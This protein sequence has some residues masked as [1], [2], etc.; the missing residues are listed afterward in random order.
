[1]K[2]FSKIIFIVF[3][4][5][6]SLCL[7]V[8]VA[9]FFVLKNFDLNKFKPQIV[10]QVQQVLGRQ[11]QVGDLAVGFSLSQGLSLSVSNVAIL[12]DAQFSQ[13]PFISVGKLSLGLD[14]FGIIAQRQ[15]S[16]STV[17]IRDPQIF[18]IRN[19]EGV[20]NFQSLAVFN[21]DN[22]NTPA[23]AAA[24][25]APA[26]G[27]AVVLVK[28]IMVSNGV[29]NLEDHWE[30]DKV[31]QLKKI[32]LKVLDFSL[33]NPF[34]ISMKAACL[35]DKQ[36]MTA[37]SIATID[38]L[39][40]AGALR[41][42]QTE[43]DMSTIDV[44]LLAA[45]IPAMAQ[46]KLQDPLG[47]KLTCSADE[48]QMSAQGVLIKKLQ[49][50]LSGGELKTSYLKIP[51]KNIEAK[52]EIAGEN[53][54]IPSASCA[55]GQGR[56]DFNGTINQ[57]LSTQEYKFNITMDG[58][59]LGQVVNQGGQDVAFEGMASGKSVV[60]GKGFEALAA[61]NPDSGQATLHI[62]DGKLVNIN[63]LKIVLDKMSML[64]NLTE[65]LQQSL[66]EKYRATLEKNDTQI[67]AV[68]FDMNIQAGQVNVR[69]A[70]VQ[71]DIF[72]LLGQGTMD[73]K[74]HMNLAT[75][76]AIPQDLSAS[77]VASVKELKFL[78]DES[79]EIVIPV[80][81][82]GRAPDRLSY[83]PDLAYL[84]QRIIETKGK[85]ELGRLL[86]KVLDRGSAGEG[87]PSSSP[88]GEEII[89]N[90]LDAIFKK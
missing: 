39:H 2:K 60:Q 82:Q 48:I 36:N 7:L 88:S 73:L 56:M 9:L 37:A 69:S 27:V 66:P 70:K 6:L 49:G 30:E 13:K 53:L 28:N 18:L 8:S 24:S 58:V 26:V 77:M 33:V 16:I 21:K 35:S 61:L 11:A 41:D 43:V 29:V 63:I 23:P 83:M 4:V 71:A 80:D 72:S 81:V 5:I 10:A 52:V 34:K 89:G 86:D 90:V 62:Q 45:I 25:A 64:P 75:R 42:L 68:D 15:V 20:F 78:T 55:L 57:Y 3:T 76:I 67:S 17:E 1:M 44:K 19:E 12:D 22:A 40:A 14:L 87:D 47:G 50:D 38:A 85:E 65:E 74:L 79:G 46:A 32:D 84:G 54:T 51:V 59:S 31:V